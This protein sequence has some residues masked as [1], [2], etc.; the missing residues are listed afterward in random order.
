MIVPM[1]KYDFVLHY[2]CYENFLEQLQELGLVDITTTG[3][4]P[5]E[6]DRRLL[7]QIEQHRQAANR[8][9]DLTARKDFTPGEPFASGKEAFVHYQEAVREI[10]SLTARIARLHKE[11]DELAVWGEFSPE[12][13]ARL[14]ESGVELRFFSTYDKDF[15]NHVATWR[16]Q[17][18]IER[19]ASEEGFTYFVAIVSPDTDVAINAQELRKPDATRNDKLRE[20]ASLEAELE[21][22]N[23]QLARCAAS[24]EAIATHEKS[25][26]ERL[27]FRQVH[28]SGKSAADGSLVLLEGWATCETAD[29]VDA[30]LEEFS[31]LIYLKSDPTPDD[32]T[33]IL[34]KNNRFAR[35]FELIGRFYSL[36][37]YGTMDL[38]PYFGPFYMI[39]FGFCLGDGGYGLLF[40]L[41]GLLM[42]WKGGMKLRQTAGLTIWCGAATVLFG[43]LTGSFF[44]V[45]LAGLP[46]FSQFRDYFLSSEK[47]F[48]LSI[49]LG[50]IQILFGMALK[51]A[52]TTRLFGF[53]YA[54]S[55]IGW[56][57]VI[58]STIAAMFL[59]DLGLTGFSMSSIGY[60]IC[61]G[62]G[63]FMMLFL[64]SPGKNPLANFGAGLW[65]TYNDVTGLM[66]DV[67]SYIR[68]FAIG[69]SGSVLALVFNDLALGLSPDI[70][71]VGVIVTI[72]I[73]L[74]GHG[75]NLFMS[76]LG[77]FVH[78]MRLTFVEFYKNAG[79]EESQRPFTPFKHDTK[80]Q[81]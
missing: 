6:D 5:S 42:R 20:I 30:M 32:D 62:I 60:L 33:P 63:L 45:Q 44:G 22:W 51:T 23:R 18:I 79:F 41:A 50:L 40:V 72:I 28:D 48:N 26:R 35:L 11:A 54:L 57:I 73:L 47:L 56:M 46:L 36:P 39:F 16:E 10:E 59:P 21:K 17:Y 12:K 53:R 31:D 80:N 75:I 69:L 34:L 43:L 14:E 78:P 71:V 25:L 37:K 65:N 4:E 24:Q 61:L 52:V 7:A 15:D 8:F 64:N 81:A 77:S 13:I 2:G 74:I 38:T 68:L 3:W 29:K 66:S 76:S 55:T 27:Q 70:P 49:A 58:V 9:K 19:I 67:L 1:I